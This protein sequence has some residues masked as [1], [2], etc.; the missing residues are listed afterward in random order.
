MIVLREG[1]EMMTSLNQQ[2]ER[3]CCRIKEF[4]G[5]PRFISRI[6]AIG[7]TVGARLKVVQNRRHYP[8]LVSARDTMIALGPGEAAHIWVE[9]V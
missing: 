6:T 4:Q 1:E 3:S 9:E 7:L 8:V 5:T 2:P